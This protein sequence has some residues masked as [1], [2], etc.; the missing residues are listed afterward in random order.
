VLADAGNLIEAERV[1][2]A[3]RARDAGDL[4]NQA[5]LL[6]RIVDLDLRAGRTGDA[7][8]NLREGLNIAVRT[9]N[10]FELLT[11][12]SQ[13]GDL[14]A[15][16]GRAAEALTLWPHASQSTSV[17]EPPP[18][19]PGSCPAGTN[20]CARPG[21]RWHPPGRGRPRTAVRR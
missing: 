21:R 1:G 5:L 12:L 16:T 3:G 7:A 2:A 10:W 11:G 19:R 15:A 20:S 13:C 9:A 14:C 6:P 18:T 8:A 4:W 17:G